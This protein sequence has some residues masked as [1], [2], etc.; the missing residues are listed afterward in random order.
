MDTEAQPPPEIKAKKALSDKKIQALKKA[1][2]ALVKTRDEK[3]LSLHEHA[4]DEVIDRK[5]NAKFE[6]LKLNAPPAPPPPPPPPPT[7][8]EEDVFIKRKKKKPV[9]I[10]ELSSS[11]PE[12]VY[13]KPRP[14]SK[15]R[16]KPK[17][18]PQPQEPQNDMMAMYR[19][20]LFR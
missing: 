4:L 7:D 18:Q 15:P 13:V 5:L 1:R 3:R 19:D 6:A 12:P 20:L 10:I 16:S 11:E 17:P 9:R 14:K 8:S 2:S